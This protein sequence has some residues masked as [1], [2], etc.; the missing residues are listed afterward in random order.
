MLNQYKVSQILKSV[1]DKY[2]DE[3][4]GEMIFMKESTEFS[5]STICG[6]H[7]ITFA[8]EFNNDASSKYL[9]GFFTNRLEDS[10]YALAPNLFECF[11]VL[12]EIGH[13]MQYVTE[14][15]IN[16]E[17]YKEYKVKTYITNEQ[18]MHTYREIPAEVYADNFAMDFINNNIKKLWFILDK[19]ADRE[20]VEF[21]TSLT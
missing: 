5:F 3:L 8:P 10:F 4:D 1:K 17:G 12:H 20:E 18:A 2:F 16:N 19:D 7:D 14:G 15:N 6:V 9:K 11:A 13:L 21:F